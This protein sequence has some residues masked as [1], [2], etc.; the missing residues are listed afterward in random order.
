[1]KI[2]CCDRDVTVKLTCL[3]TP[4]VLF[5]DLTVFDS[6]VSSLIC[7]VLPL[8]VIWNGQVSVTTG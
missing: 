3:G 7:L 2:S 8:I 4:A 6:E 5:S 1:M